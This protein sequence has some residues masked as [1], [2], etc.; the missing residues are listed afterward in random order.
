MWDTGV[1]VRRAVADGVCEIGCV[2]SVCVEGVRLTG[3]GV[4]AECDSGI[5]AVLAAG[6]VRGLEAAGCICEAG[7]GRMRGLTDAARTC[8][9]A[10]N[11]PCFFA[12]PGGMHPP[13]PGEQPQPVF[14][15]WLQPAGVP[16]L[17]K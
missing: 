4:I 10:C 6:R 8:E 2:F 11:P 14:L 5:R 17:A 7:C 9:A 13:D 12:R 3:S 15:P 16:A 1:G